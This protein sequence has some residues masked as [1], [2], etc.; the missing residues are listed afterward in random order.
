MKTGTTQWKVCHGFYGRVSL[1]HARVNSQRRPSQISRSKRDVPP[2]FDRLHRDQS[3]EIR[4]YGETSVNV[5]FVC[6]GSGR[7]VIEIV[8]AWTYTLRQ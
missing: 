4:A 7:C 6:D 1:K 3:F 5:C 2:G 8:S